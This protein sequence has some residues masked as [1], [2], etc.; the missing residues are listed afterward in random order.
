MLKIPLFLK[1]KSVCKF[2][3]LENWGCFLAEPY[4]VGKSDLSSLQS[5]CSYSA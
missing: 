1:K 4:T 5:H 2:Q 3:R